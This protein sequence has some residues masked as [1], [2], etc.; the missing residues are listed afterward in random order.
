LLL[1]LDN[2]EHL[3]DACVQ[4]VDR[5]LRCSS[6]VVMLVTSR[7]R[8]GL[9]G[10]RT[11]RVPSLTVPGARE[12]STPQTLSRYEGV[13]LFVERAKLVRPDFDLMAEN[14]SCV[15]SICARLDGMP[16]AI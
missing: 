14:A 1:V 15:A 16:L 10:E 8:L 3:L 7:Q 4:L 11:Y 6:S 2:A 9:A 13:R 5:I 12:T